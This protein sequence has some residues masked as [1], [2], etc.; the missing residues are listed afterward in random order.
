[1]KRVLDVLGALILLTI[2]GPLF[3]VITILILL[4]TPGPTVYASQRV[5]K[6]GKLFG[7]L[8]F[9]TV[10]LRH[11]HH[12]NMDDRLNRV[13]RLLRNLSLDDLPNVI[14]VLRGE[15]S[16]V[17]PRPMEPERIDQNDPAS[18]YILSTRPGMISYAILM[19]ARE[20]NLSSPEQKQALELKYVA[21]QSLYFD[22]W[23]LATAIRSLIASRGNIKARGTPRK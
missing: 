8:R 7:L 10:D 1:L 2:T 22:G 19:L 11:P 16:F 6:G 3:L 13:G 20:Y 14:N 18:Q 12:L 4:D 21:S 17:G 15:M 9:R 23:I 5:G